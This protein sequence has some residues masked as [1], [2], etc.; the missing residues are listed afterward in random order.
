MEIRNAKKTDKV[1]VA[2]LIYSA[3]PELYDFIYQNNQHTAQDYIAYEFNSGRGF[4]GYNNVTVAV[5]NGEVV[6]T[7]CFYDGKQYDKLLLGTALNM[8][9]FYG[10]GV[11]SALL[12]SSHI[13]SVMKKP[14]KDELYLA[15]FG[16]LTTLRG[17]GIGRTLIESQLATAKQRGYRIFALDV[18]DTNPRA[19]KLYS[20]LG[21]VVTKVKTFSGKREGITVPNSKKME[22]EL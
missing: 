8:C 3:G 10:F 18:A 19:E 6:A 2:A 5:K 14:K 1:N 13:S 7:G 11:A 22:K 21:L 4:C 17:Q 16:V 15:N 9:L 12:R 20:S